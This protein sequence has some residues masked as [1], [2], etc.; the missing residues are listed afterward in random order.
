MTLPDFQTLTRELAD[1]K[2]EAKIRLEAWQRYQTRKVT[3]S[4]L[5]GLRGRIEFLRQQLKPFEAKI[6]DRRFSQQLYDA[7]KRVSYTKHDLDALFDG[8]YFSRARWL[9]FQGARRTL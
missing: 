1:A 8:V 9:R 6:R 2:Q 4:E 5:S 7:K 3:D